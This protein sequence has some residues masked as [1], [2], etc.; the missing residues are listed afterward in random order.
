MVITVLGSSSGQAVASRNPS[1]LLVEAPDTTLLIDAGDGVVRQM[2]KI[3]LDPGRI[4][5]VCISHTHPDHA[6]GLPFLLQQMILMNRQSPLEIYLPGEL[7]PGFESILPYFQI[8][9]EKYPGLFVFKRLENEKAIRFADLT[10]EPVLNS[11][12][13]SIRTLAE[14]LGIST[15]SYSFRWRSADN[16]AVLYT[17]DVT[18]LLHLK[19]HTEEV[20][21]LISECTH[22]PVDE[23]LKFT[24]DADILHLIL[25][26]ISPELEGEGMPLPDVENL[27]IEVAYDG[28]TIEA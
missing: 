22:L 24:Q 23:I 8:Y 20:K 6:G 18:D 7:L 3:G 26:H 16:P 27:H 4:D 1:A 10:L 13:Q 15:E 21:L 14:P 17:S 19:D 5:T 2:L 11:H 9:P 25:T 12:L 28:F